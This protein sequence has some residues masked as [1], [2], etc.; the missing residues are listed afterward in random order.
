MEKS[1]PKTL[2]Y[3]QSFIDKVKEVFPNNAEMKRMAENSEY[4]L[5]R[6][7]DDSSSSNIP[8]QRVLEAKTPADWAFLQE[9]AYNELK[10]KELY[11]QWE[12]EVR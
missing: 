9:Y 6:L 7:L 8:I 10:K 11:L 4:F 5:G 1:A 3:S 2:Q 12:K